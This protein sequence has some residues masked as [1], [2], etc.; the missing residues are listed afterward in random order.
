MLFVPRKFTTSSAGLHFQKI[1]LIKRNRAKNWH[2]K[3]FFYYRAK[4]Y[5]DEK[6]PADGSQ[7]D[8]VISFLTER[9]R[10]IKLMQSIPGD[11]YRN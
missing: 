6:E 1:Y 11:S 7:P 2:K 3:S 5:E 9:R 8:A 10:L 4:F